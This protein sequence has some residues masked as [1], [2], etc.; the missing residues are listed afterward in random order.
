MER[1]QTVPVGDGVN[2]LMLGIYVLTFTILCFLLYGAIRHLNWENGMWFCIGGLAWS[3]LAY[4]HIKD[5]NPRS[6][7]FIMRFRNNNL[8]AVHIRG[9][10]FLIPFFESAMPVK[11]PLRKFDGSVRVNVVGEDNHTSVTGRGAE[12]TLPYTVFGYL[13]PEYAASILE[14]GVNEAAGANTSVIDEQELK[15]V[16]LPLTDSRVRV[17]AAKMTLDQL[18][19]CKGQKI[20]A[21]E[22]IGKDDVSTEV[23]NGFEITHILFGDPQESAVVVAARDEA[24]A[25]LARREAQQTRNTINSETLAMIRKDVA[26]MIRDNPS[27]NVDLVFASVARKH[28]VEVEELKRYDVNVTGLSGLSHFQVAPEV[29]RSGPPSNKGTS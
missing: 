29:L 8:V 15:G 28:G 24:Q 20:S 26:R 9:F 19:A 14:M 4:D 23:P 27:L 17:F 2:N 7:E 16:V 10:V 5:I 21:S 18:N 6:R 11:N 22:V 1:N 12:V 3:F 13:R 25:E